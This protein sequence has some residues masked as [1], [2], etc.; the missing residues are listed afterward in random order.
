MLAPGLWPL[1]EVEKQFVRQSREGYGSARCFVGAQLA[2]EPARIRAKLGRALAYV[3]SKHPMLSCVLVK[4]PAHGVVLQRS[5]MAIRASD[6]PGE[7]WMDVFQRLAKV[8][9]A[10]NKLP[11]ESRA[12]SRAWAARR[13]RLSSARV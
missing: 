6:F 5:D 2:V 10:L 8:P 7:A 13:S 4:H 12:C 11:V 3:Q 1:G 9:L